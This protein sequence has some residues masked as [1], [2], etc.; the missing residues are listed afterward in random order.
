[1]KNLRKYIEL[2]KYI[3]CGNSGSERQTTH[4]MAHIFR[5]YV[6]FYVYNYIGVSAEVCLQT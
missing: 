6:N 4:L 3:K 2:E 5:T 1:M